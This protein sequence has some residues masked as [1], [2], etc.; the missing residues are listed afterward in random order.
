MGPEF[1]NC[2]AT[3]AGRVGRST[4]AVVSSFGPPFR[5]GVLDQSPVSAGRSAHAAIAETLE[6]AQKTEAWGYERYWLAEHH[7]AGSFAGTRPLLI[8]SRVASLTTKIRVGTGG[9]MLMHASALAVAEQIRTLEALFPGRIDLG[10]GRAPGGGGHTSVA[11][12]PNGAPPDLDQDLFARKL[13]DLGDLL[14]GAASGP[15]G[16]PPAHPHAGVFAQPLSK[17]EPGA[18]QP[19]L[20]GS[21]SKSAALAARLGWGFCFA[22]FLGG[23][24]G[25]SVVDEYREHFR[26]SPWL[27]KPRV[28]VAA[29]V[30]AADTNDEAEAL[31]SSTELWFL[32]T[33]QGRREPFPSVEEALAHAWTPAELRLRD[34]TRALRIRGGPERVRKG[35]SRL[36]SRYETNELVINCITHDPAARLRSYEIVSELNQG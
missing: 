2:P 7:G 21:G 35:L 25:M 32:R 26:P 16:F 23:A 13:E 15:E 4:L 1:G 28:S 33:R 36:A 30:V 27:E 34:A 12:S 8:A 29:Y 6:L 10:I 3:L 24:T 18:T 9:I 17:L 19:W 20:L 14:H 5:L 22:A 11:L 31:L